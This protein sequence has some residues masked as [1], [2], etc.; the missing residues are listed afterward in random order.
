MYKPP[1]S[2]LMEQAC[3]MRLLRFLF[4]AER[5]RRFFKRL[6][7]PDL[8]SW[9]IDVGHYEGQ[10]AVYHNLVKHLYRMTAN[11]IERMEGAVAETNVNMRP[12]RHVRSYGLLEKLGEGSFGCV[13][14][15]VRAGSEHVYAVKEIPL[16]NPAL[17]GQTDGEQAKALQRIENEVAAA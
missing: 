1:T 13:Y 14:R 17:F 2:T 15:A 9:F 16:R 6:F 3:A 10:L 5:N 7:P 11:A 12:S 4:S 8:F